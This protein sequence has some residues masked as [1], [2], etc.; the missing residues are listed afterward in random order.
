M[1][2][3]NFRV[4]GFTACPS[5]SELAALA[6]ERSVIAMEDLGSGSIHG[7]PG[8]PA[9]REVVASGMDLV[10]FSADKL[11]GGPQAGLIVG[12][13]EAVS[14]LRNHPMYRALRLD[15]VA[16]AALEATLALHV[17][18]AGTEVDR[19]L[20][21][22][23]EDI[24]ARART[25]SAHL[26]AMNVPSE[27]CPGDAFTGGGA[28]PGKRLPSWVVALEHNSPESLSKRLRTGQPAVVGRVH[29]GRYLLD[30]RT[31]HPSETEALAQRVASA[32]E[33]G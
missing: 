9:V 26:E 27:V 32:I 16:L 1:H 17:S 12:T 13:R 33:V 5:R 22:A 21:E 15:K 23:L 11:L 30:L 6:H 29:Q 3:S 28:L 10:T 7:R 14:R 24:E 18:G 31:V 8:E 2:P 19:M 20:D 25:L 4:V